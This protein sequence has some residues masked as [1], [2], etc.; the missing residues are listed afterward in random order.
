M[1]KNMDSMAVHIVQTTGNMAIA[2]GS[3]MVHKKTGQAKYYRFQRNMMSVL[4]SCYKKKAPVAKAPY[5]LL[6]AESMVD[7]PRRKSWEDIQQAYL[8]AMEAARHNG[9][10]IFVE[11]YGYER[12]AKLAQDRSDEPKA[13]FYLQEALAMYTRWGATVKMTELSERLE[14]RR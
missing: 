7:K 9:G 11:A 5:L 8:E 14:G 6:V 13:L 2:L 10:F 3:R 12:L 1:V 4:R